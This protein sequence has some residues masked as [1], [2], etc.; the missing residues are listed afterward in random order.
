MKECEALAAAASVLLPVPRGRGTNG[1]E[2]MGVGGAKGSK[3][4]VQSEGG[5]LPTKVNRNN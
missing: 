3:N 1:N 2:G 4:V 5:S